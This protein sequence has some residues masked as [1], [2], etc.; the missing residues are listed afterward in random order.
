L[1]IKTD[2]RGSKE[3]IMGSLD[4]VIKQN[5]DIKCPIHVVLSSI[6]DISES[7]I[8]L[9]A[10]THSIILGLH[11]RAE[12]NAQGLAKEHGVDVQTF[13]IIYELIDY[14]QKLLESK[15]EVVMTWKKV[16]EAVVKKVFDIKGVGIIA[17]CYMRDGVLARGNK[18]AC[19]RSGKQLGEGIVG[20]L[21]RERK[22]VK[23]IHAGFECGFTTDGFSE[24]QEGDTVMCYAK[25]K[26]E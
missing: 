13:Y 10:D 22:S 15:K 2:T 11:V 1:I 5:K 3:A 17:G 18:V 4:K 12:K 7:D 8:D 24:W 26:A 25:V 21:Q 19:M 20:T 23:E 16:G 6:G 9:A 14:L